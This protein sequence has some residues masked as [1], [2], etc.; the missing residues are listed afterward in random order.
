MLFQLVNDV[1]AKIDKLP[2]FP[3]PPEL[4]QQIRAAA[5]E[6]ITGLV[7][8]NKAQ[9]K[10]ISEADALKTLSLVAYAAIKSI[11]RSARAMVEHVNDRRYGAPQRCALAG[12][13]AYLVQPHD[14]IPD[15][16]PGYY[17]YLDDAIILQAGLVEYLDTF[18]AGDADA[19]EALA[20]FFVSLTPP[21]VRQQVQLVVS[22]QSQLLQMLA[23]I[24][25]EMAELTLQMIVANPLQQGAG[26]N[27]QMPQGFQVP[28][29][30]GMHPARNYLGGLGSGGFF[31]RSGAYVEGDN[32]IMPGGGGLINGQVFVP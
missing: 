26:G 1:C 2:P 5:P 15:N 30:F 3:P 19:Q 8:S 27:F 16:A 10:T 7:Q 28:G 4:G 13:L 21:Q 22:S 23:V 14:L 9:G 17:G 31:G 25:P 12:I 32:I 29:G 24:G 20:R 6:A 11:P 18:P